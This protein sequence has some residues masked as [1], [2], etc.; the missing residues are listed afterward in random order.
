MAVPIAENRRILT[1]SNGKQVVIP[2][3]SS[4]PVMTMTLVDELAAPVP[5][6]AVGTAT[7]TIYAR[8]EPTQPIINS[9]DHV[10]IKNTGRGTMHA[11]S[12]LLTVSL[13]TADNSIQNSANDLE[14]HR[15]LI[16]ITYN[17]TKALKYEIEAPVRNLQKV[18]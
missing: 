7:L 13:E 17:S 8:D 14:W 11:T 10:N 16:E 15:F 18:T 3:K 2:E 4:G 12:G 9:V 5:L 6:S 1:D